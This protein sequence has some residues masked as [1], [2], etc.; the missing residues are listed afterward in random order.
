MESS[1]NMAERNPDDPERK[2]NDRIRQTSPVPNEDSAEWSAETD[3][4][5]SDHSESDH[6]ESD[7][8]ESAQN[9]SAHPEV[10][11]RYRI[12]RV[13]GRGG[14]G[15]VYLAYD[16]QLDRDVAVKVPHAK[17]ISNEEDADAYRAEAQTVAKLDHP[18]IVPV[19]DAGGTSEFP[20]YVVSKYVEGANLA[21]RFGSVGF[22]NPRPRSR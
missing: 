16:E 19:Y 7:H 6:S 15:L 5:E 17:L 1:Q 9:E 8:S 13:L 22:R 10:I 12:E 14:F 21:V 3:H 11:G 2:A 18:N 20:F 4:A